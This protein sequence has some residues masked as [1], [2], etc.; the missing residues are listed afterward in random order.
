MNKKTIITITGVL[1]ASILVISVLAGIFSVKNEEQPP[2]RPLHSDNPILP[3]SVKN[4]IDELT[5]NDIGP[6]KI[7]LSG[8]KLMLYLKDELIDETVVAPEVLPRA[9]VKAL[10]D[11]ITYKTIED[12]L[13]DWESLCN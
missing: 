4:V 9:D 1:S 5:D 8:N 13:I 3:T 6:Y 11:G 7:I 12:A 2:D 10:T